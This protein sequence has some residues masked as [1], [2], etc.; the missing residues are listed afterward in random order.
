MFVFSPKKCQGRV[1]KMGN[2]GIMRLSVAKLPRNGVAVFR[3]C[4]GD[5]KEKIRENGEK[6]AKR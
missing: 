3:R 4:G 2:Y 5:T 1:A 6:T